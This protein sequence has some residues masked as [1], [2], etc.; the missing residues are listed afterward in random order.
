MRDSE[1][2]VKWW[3]IEMAG[4]TILSCVEAEQ[5]STDGAAV[6]YIEAESQEAAERKV[7]RKLQAAATRARRKRDI[8]QGLCPWCRKKN[9]RGP[10]EN[11]TRCLERKKVYGRN[12]RARIQG[13]LQDVAPRMP[14]RPEDN[15]KRWAKLQL[16]V[17][18]EVK[19]EWIAAPNERAFTGWIESKISRLV[20][21]A[22]T[23]EA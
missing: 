3:R 19:R 9:D 16:D 14:M 23:E 11:C 7:L 17:L 20:Q 10:G 5:P 15:N 18:R 2:S 21:A 6:L 22:G 4:A 8:D 1:F 12:A 13:R